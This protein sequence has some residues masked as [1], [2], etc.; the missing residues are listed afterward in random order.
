MIERVNISNL[1]AT[2]AGTVELPR[3]VLFVGENGT[4]KTTYL[5]AIKLAITG[6]LP[7]ASVSGTADIFKLAN[8]AE[9][10]NKMSDGLVLSD[11][12][13]IRTW[14]RKSKRDPGTGEYSEKVSQKI[15]LIPSKDERTLAEKEARIRAECGIDPMVVDVSAFLDMS[16]NKRRDFFYQIGGSRE[17][18]W[19]TVD[20][21][22]GR[23]L[24]ANNNKPLEFRAYRVQLAD[25]WGESLESLLNYLADEQKTV[26]REIKQARGA[27]EQMVKI[28]GQRDTV[29]GDLKG[30][31][32]EL[33]RTREQKDDLI[34]E[35]SKSEALAVA[36]RERE[37]RLQYLTQR[38]VGLEDYSTLPDVEDLRN[39]SNH[40][41]TELDKLKNELAKKA[42][43]LKAEKEKADEA[44]K[45]ANV[46]HKAAG[47]EYLKLEGRTNAFESL[48][49]IKKKLCEKC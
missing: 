43:E 46:D 20:S 13:F 4:G 14:E 32:E 31:K 40:F 36:I 17:V 10:V 48:K 25:K 3:V 39:L 16:D 44:L 23:W 18:T 47:D 24:E 33:A 28:K 2:V 8:S 15:E 11:F 49:D 45:K 19:D 37:E 35:I 34:C 42:S 41:E 38:L 1:K 30:L 12:S 29:A 5:Q 9:G 21:V 6:A 26:N 22:L 27:A 7:E